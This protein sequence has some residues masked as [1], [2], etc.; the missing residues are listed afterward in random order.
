MVSDDI[1]RAIILSLQASERRLKAGTLLKLPIL[2]LLALDN[3]ILTLYLRG[4]GSFRSARSMDA[5][6][7]ALDAAIQASRAIHGLPTRT[8]GTGEDRSTGILNKAETLPW[9]RQPH[10]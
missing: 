4:A 3:I 8:R 2:E 10:Q 6:C 7:A 1:W 5:R 9:C